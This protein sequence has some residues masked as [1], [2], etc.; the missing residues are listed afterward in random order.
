MRRVTLRSRIYMECEMFVM[1]WFSCTS[2]AIYISWEDT[3]DEADTAL[4]VTETDPHS[5]DTAT[6][7][8][9]VDEDTGFGWGV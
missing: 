5:T 3:H 7:L 2:K 9:R 8:D 4:F 1:M 6:G